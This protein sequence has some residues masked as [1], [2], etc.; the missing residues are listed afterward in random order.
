MTTIK[1]LGSGCKS[2]KRTAKLFE[3]TAAELGLNPTV[4]KVTD[5]ATIMQYGALAT[6]GVV[7]DEEL[8]HSGGVPS[9]AQ[10]RAWLEAL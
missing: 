10:V 7:I 5:M 4:E 8:I 6:P 3:T 9:P 1:I 2:C